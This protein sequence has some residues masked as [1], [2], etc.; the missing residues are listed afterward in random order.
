[1][2]NLLISLLIIL[3]I[4]VVGFLIISVVFGIAAVVI[5]TI[6][7]LLKGARDNDERP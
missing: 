1:M 3:G 2:L 4:I 5:G 7:Y 6:S